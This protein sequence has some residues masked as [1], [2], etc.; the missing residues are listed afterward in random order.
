VRVGESKLS[1]SGSRCRPKVESRA[2][3]APA[4]LASDHC[5]V[6]GGGPRRLLPLRVEVQVT[7]L[8]VHPGVAVLGMGGG[9]PCPLAMKRNSFDSPSP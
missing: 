9:Q 4:P 1:T 2:A 6:F 5:F 3:E 8:V 7:R